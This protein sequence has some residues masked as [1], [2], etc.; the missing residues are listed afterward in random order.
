[1]YIFIAWKCRYVY[2]RRVGQQKVN[3]QKSAHSSRYPNIYLMDKMAKKIRS[4]IG[5]SY[6][7]ARWVHCG[8]K[9]NYCY[10]GR[11]NFIHLVLAKLILSDFF[12]TKLQCLKKFFTFTNQLKGFSTEILVYLLCSLFGPL[13]KWLWKRYHSKHLSYQQYIYI[14]LCLLR[15]ILH[16]V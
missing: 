13:F 9:N 7:S 4:K 12:L 11:L 1:M 5:G 2:E 15:P 3:Q 16:F 10:T 6:T 14:S 8:L